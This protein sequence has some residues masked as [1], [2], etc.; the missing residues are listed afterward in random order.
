MK[1]HM[2]RRVQ[3][4]LVSFN[5]CFD[6]SKCFFLKFKT[7]KQM[8]QFAVQKNSDNGF[9]NSQKRLCYY[10]KLHHHERTPIT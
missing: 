1:H 2:N 10:E 7:I 8:P 9:F 4:S 5:Y 3:K 6:K